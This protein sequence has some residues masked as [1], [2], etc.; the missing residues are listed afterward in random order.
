M[1]SKSTS[2]GRASA[3]ISGFRAGFLSLIVLLSNI[4][5][6]LAQTATVTGTVR[7]DGDSGII[8]GPPIA[9]IPGSKLY[10]YL[11]S[12][13]NMIVDSSVVDSA[14]GTYSLVGTLNSNYKVALASTA[15]GIGTTN[16]VLGLPST[17]V[18]S[19]EGVAAAGDGTPDYQVAITLTSNLVVNFAI[20]A[21][22][23]GNAYNVT[24]PVYDA[25]GRI[26]IPAAAFSGTDV[27]DGVYT[28]GY[29]GRS[30][31]LFDA[32]GGDI[33][34]NGTLINATTASF[35]SRIANFDTSL[36][37]FQPFVG[38]TV[39]QFSYNTVD[40][41][42]ATEDVPNIVSVPGP[43]PIKLFSFT[44][45]AK[46]NSN[47]LQWQTATESNNYGFDIERSVDGI[48][49]TTIGNVSSKAKNGNS[50]Q[51]LSYNYS[52]YVAGEPVQQ[53]FIYR[54]KQIDYDGRSTY[55]PIVR[56]AGKSMPNVLTFSTYPNP[57]MGLINLNMAT[58]STIDEPLNITLLNASGAVALTRSF[59][60]KAGQLDASLDLSALPAGIYYM[61]LRCN[62]APAQVQQV[63]LQPH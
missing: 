54:L 60:V 2:C 5:I 7:D 26:R 49:F 34:Y 41:G 53:S 45:F 28:P 23:V 6:S 52:D 10:V 42:G 58:G 62:S 21:R 25:S 33:Y 39:H 40:N 48:S 29:Q 9:S 14:T 11:K 43:L 35:A 22:P 37:R 27:E 3:H 31:N 51:L 32:V 15:Y 4:T 24:N 55:S 8:S 17:Y 38:Y 30:I 1:Q 20:N 47:M 63:V 12:N 56:I 19:A 57:S 16:P 18:A 13:A 36:L 50:I 46:G 59:E 44:G 61:Q